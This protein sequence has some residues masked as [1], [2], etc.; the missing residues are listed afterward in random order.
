[1]GI[2][3]EIGDAEAAD[4]EHLLDAVLQQRRLER[5]RVYRL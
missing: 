4:A 1:V 3:A 5:K 2:T